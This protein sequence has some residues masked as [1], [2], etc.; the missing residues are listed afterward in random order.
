MMV[1]CVRIQKRSNLIHARKEG[2]IIRPCGS[3]H[4]M[5][6]YRLKREVRE[7]IT[8]NKMSHQ[9]INLPPLSD[10]YPF[11]SIDTWTRESSSERKIT[12]VWCLLLLIY[13]PIYLIKI[14]CTCARHM[15]NSFTQ[16]VDICSAMAAALR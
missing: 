9:S 6:I 11:T 8:L 12:Q 3:F 15:K 2:I 7:A 14:C 10:V 16:R 13:F 4:L 1:A 5:V